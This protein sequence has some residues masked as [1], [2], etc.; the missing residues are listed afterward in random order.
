MCFACQWFNRERLKKEKEDKEEK[1]TGSFANTIKKMEMEA[2]A[3]DPE[4]SGWYK[5]ILDSTGV[6]FNASKDFYH[7]IQ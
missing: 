4:N 3:R 5:T 6:S 1:Q 7:N 2:T